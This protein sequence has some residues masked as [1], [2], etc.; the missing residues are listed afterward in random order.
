MKKL[1]LIPLLLLCGCSNT[2]DDIKSKMEY[3]LNGYDYDKVIVEEIRNNDKV[4]YLVY[5][6]DHHNKI[7]GGVNYGIS[8]YVYKD[9]QFNWIYSC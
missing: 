6:Y 2:K 7:N 5:V 4:A 3:K 1:L 8:I 9:N